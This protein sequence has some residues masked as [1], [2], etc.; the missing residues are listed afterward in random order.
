MFNFCNFWACNCAG[1]Y[2]VN[3]KSMCETVQYYLE[4]FFVFFKG[5]KRQAFYCRVMS[6]Q[7]TISEDYMKTHRY[8]RKIDI[9]TIYQINCNW[10]LWDKHMKKKLICGF[11][12]G[13]H[14]NLINQYMNWHIYWSRRHSICL[15]GIW[16]WKGVLVTDESRNLPCPNIEWTNNIH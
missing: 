1:V 3:F 13:H 11:Q 16:D 9:N 5:C 12:K 15:K 8:P 7:N 10:K 2:W 6:L 4:K 14:T